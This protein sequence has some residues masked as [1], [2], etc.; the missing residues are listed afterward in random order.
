MIPSNIDKEKIITYA[1]GLLKD[2][3]IM[4]MYLGGSIA[5]GIYEKEYSDIDVNVFVNGL[6]GFIHTEMDGID[7]FIYGD[8]KFLSRQ[9]MSSDLSLYN[10]IFIDDALSL[11]DTLI[12]LN[13]V[14]ESE[15]NSFKNIRLE[16]RLKSF[17]EMN[18]QYYEYHLNQ[19]H[20][21]SKK[22]YHLFRWRGIIENY[23]LTGKLTLDIAE[24]W[25][26]KMF[27]Y[28]HDWNTET[29]VRLHTELKE[30]IEYIKKYKEGLIR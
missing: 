2:K 14:F 20:K 9:D 24:P 25:K 11:D 30:I 18:V 5:F 17:L 4:F 27:S 19:Y 22:M 26:A 3:E 1:K 7:Y 15:F 10:K 16:D 28:K 29:G 8:D 6:K 23:K 13:P 12:Y 21:P